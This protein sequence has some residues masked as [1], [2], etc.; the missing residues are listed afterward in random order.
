VQETTG[1]QAA[2]LFRLVCPA[3]R[4]TLRA[5]GE[6]RSCESC[7]RSFQDFATGIPDL[8]LSYAD[9]QLTRDEDAE[10]ARNL[11]AR[12][13]TVDFAELLDEHWRLV[14]KPPELAARFTAQELKAR[15]RVEPVVAAIEEAGGAPL[16]AGARILEVGCGSAALS[17]ALARRGP[18]VVAT[19]VSLRWLVLARERLRKEATTAVELAACAAEALPLPEASFDLVAASDVIEHIESPDRFAAECARVLRPGGLLFLATPNRYSLGLEPHVRLPAVGYLPRPLAKRYVEAVRH[20]SY[21]HVR[22]L[23][24]RGLRQTLER[25]GLAVEIVAPEIPRASQELYSG[26][27]LALVR[28]YNRVRRNTAVHGALLAVGPFF[29]VFA[30]KRGG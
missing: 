16:G 27:E 8:R 14:G 3:C 9:P 26:A 17:A 21:D 7:G 10:L 22:L 13:A 28:A 20:T 15:D 23:S 5:I 12:T 25:S 2:S 6:L 11:A 24:A 19:D 30:R 1:K 18:A 4:G 29:H